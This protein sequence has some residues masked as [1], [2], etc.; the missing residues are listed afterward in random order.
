MRKSYACFLLA[1]ALIA[2]AVATTIQTISMGWGVPV[3][4]VAGDTVAVLVAI[5]NIRWG[6]D[7]RRWERRPK[8]VLHRALP[9]G[10]TAN[11][12]HVSDG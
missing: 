1:A 4:I 3:Q 12:T 5:L 10:F 9:P 8:Q 7:W 2:L 6:L 11:L